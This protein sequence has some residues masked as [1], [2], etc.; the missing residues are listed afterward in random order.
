[1]LGDSLEQRID[2]P[3]HLKLFGGDSAQAHPFLCFSERRRPIHNNVSDGQS[4][5]L[6]ASRPSPANVRCKD[7]SG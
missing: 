1:M 4:A 2:D 7:Q 6:S 5:A 3:L